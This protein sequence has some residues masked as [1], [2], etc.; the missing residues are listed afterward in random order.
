LSIAQIESGI[1]LALKAIAL[2]AA[3]ALVVSPRTMRTTADRA[4]SAA[5]RALGDQLASRE[6]D[7]IAQ[8]LDR[9][10][11]NA[12]TIELARERLSERLTS[13]EAF[14]AC[15]A[16]LQAEGYSTLGV[17]SN[18]EVDSLNSAIAM[19]KS[20]RARAARVLNAA[21]ENIRRRESDLMALEAA[22]AARRVNQL[23]ARSDADPSLWSDRIERA[24]EFLGI[25]LANGEE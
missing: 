25:A 10:R 15:A 11:Q 1:R 17:D 24:R 23:L 12:E 18:C 3:V 21:R 16:T 4:L 19:L 6:L 20:T 5:W 13:L 2:V 14:R 22:G 7:S 9:E 8:Q